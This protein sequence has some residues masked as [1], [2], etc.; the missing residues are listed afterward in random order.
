M[1]PARNQQGQISIFF[2]AS[3][4]VLISIV[5]FVINV[6]LFVKAKIN[7]QNATDAAAFA[8]A[9]V[10]ARQLSKIAYLNWEMRNIYKEWMYKYYVVGNLNI[11]DVENPSGSGK[12]SFR[13]E[14]D[15]KVLQG[16]SISDPYNLPAVCIHLSGSKT[17]IC[18]RY[19]VPGLPEFGGYSLPGPE[20]AS[21]AFLDSLIGAK[22]NDCVDRSRLNMLVT[23]T[24]AYNVLSTDLDETLTGQGPAILSDRQGSWPRAVELAMRM[25]NLEFVMNKKAFS[26]GVCKQQSGSGNITCTKT[27]EELSSENEL[28]NERLVKAF[29]TGYRN[30]GGSDPQDEMKNTFTLKEIAPKMPAAGTKFSASNLLIPEGKIYPKQYVDLKLMMVNL[31]TFYAALIPRGNKDD[32]GACDISKVALPVPGYPLGFYKNPDVVTYYAVKGEADFVGMFNPFNSKA[33]KLT[34]YSAAKPFGG[35]VGPML[36]FQKEGTDSFK[37]RNDSGKLRS[38]PYFASLNV[39]GTPRKETGGVLAEGEYT[40]GAPLPVNGTKAFWLKEPD[41]AVGGL[42][43]SGDGVQFGIPNLA[44]DFTDGSFTSASYSESE[45]KIHI[46]TPKNGE[47]GDKSIGLFSKDQFRA[48]KGTVSRNITPEALRAEIS[49]VRSATLYESANYMIPTADDFNIKKRVDSF[50]FISGTPT[51][52]GKSLEYKAF[53][54]APLHAEGNDQKDI[55]YSNSSEVIS[56]IFQFMRAQE[57]GVMKYISSLN[58]GAKSIYDMSKPG[59]LA[60]T[61]IGSAQQ[62]QAAAAGI[63]DIAN[64]SSNDMEAIRGATPQSCK[65]LAGLFLNFYYGDPDLFPNRVADRDLC[66]QQNLGQALRKFFAQSG[67][68]PAFSASHYMMDYSFTEENFASAPQK[69]MSVFSAYM[70][71]PFNGIRENGQFTSPFAGSGISENMNRNFYSTKFVSLDSLRGG[72]GYADNQTNFPT[73]SEGAVETA[74]GFERSQTEFKNTLDAGSVDGDLSSIKY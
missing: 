10:Q 3:L 36:F 23:T 72:P 45:E 48:F 14:P 24:W 35:R 16:K 38:V 61:A 6:G 27:I 73:Y 39:V 7:L 31:A 19:A 51:P 68:N 8:G 46:I 49:R 43:N 50:G 40:S 63:S 34:A 74:S 54:Y 32:S 21:R 9:S 33:I 56:S 70:P 20:E 18:K 52:V 42:F 1:A 66:P 60:N 26:G 25:R 71:G 64:L 69:E 15:V 47:G 37:G 65:S 4:I 30:I 12:M 58:E 11:K 28:G 29:Y 62:Y 2:S 17:N 44:Y 59:V 41:G 22:I 5:A 55:L 53:I 67:N 13:L 57:S